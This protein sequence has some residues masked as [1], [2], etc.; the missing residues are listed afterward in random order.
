M[1][2]FIISPVMTQ[3]GFDQRPAL[4]KN[5]KPLSLAI[6]TKPILEQVIRDVSEVFFIRTIIYFKI[7]AYA[8]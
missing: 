1:I 2:F 4:C 6:F 8:L 5:G 7:F 3:I